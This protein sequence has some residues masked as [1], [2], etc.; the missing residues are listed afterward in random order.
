[1]KNIVTHPAL[2]IMLA[3]LLAIN[4]F[5]AIQLHGTTRDI[6]AEHH[7]ESQLHNDFQQQLQN[8]QKELSDQLKNIQY[9]LE[10]SQ[11][12]FQDLKEEAKDLMIENE[13]L[14]KKFL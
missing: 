5:F 1:M 8:E 6:Q 13:E 11:R 7:Q 14:K 9:E 3:I 12:S 10:A 2:I 4:T